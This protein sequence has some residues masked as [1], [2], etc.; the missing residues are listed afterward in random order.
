M[1]KILKTFSLL[2]ALAAICT[3]GLNTASAQDTAAKSDST[4]SKLMVGV[5]AGVNASR[6]VIN[7]S[8]EVT[9]FTP[10]FQAGA[11]VKY[12]F[13]DWVAVALEAAWSQSG[14]IRLPY[15]S[16][17]SGAVGTG[18]LTAHN[19]QFNPVLQC[20]IPVLSV[21]EP[22]FF[23]G[24]SFNV[25]YYNSFSYS[26]LVGSTPFQRNIDVTNSL[27]PLDFGLLVGAGV[28]FNLRFAVL[29]IDARY[30]HGL[31]DIRNKNLGDPFANA[32]SG[33]TEGAYI[34]NETWRSRQFSVQVGLGFPIGGK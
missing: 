9:N 8:T 2:V 7:N 4:K 34:G 23:V 13:N 24:P 28:D 5:R 27:Q 19:V 17:G 6:F 20:K 1:K 26:G 30:R 11:F 18:D 31:S 10:G 25:N 29:T 15:W 3:L 12:S 21:Y 32:R 33:Q 22:Y 14:A 16:Q